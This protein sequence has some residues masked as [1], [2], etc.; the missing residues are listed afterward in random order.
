MP[1]E[2][3]PP[4][5]AA[6]F[7]NDAQ[8]LLD[9]F[10]CKRS[11]K[12][13]DFAEV[14]CDL[15]FTTLFMGREGLRELT[16]FIEE[17]YRNTLLFMDASNPYQKVGAVYLLYAL[18]MKQ[19]HLLLKSQIP[20]RVS[21]KQV[22]DI[23]NLENH[24]LDVATS[25]DNVLDLTYI[26]TKLFKMEAFSISCFPIPMGPAVPIPLLRLEPLRNSFFK[27]MLGIL[28]MLTESDVKSICELSKRHEDLKKHLPYLC[29]SA[30]KTVGGL[31][32]FEEMKE[33]IDELE[34]RYNAGLFPNK[35]VSGD[36]KIEEEFRTL[37]QRRALLKSQQYERVAEFRKSKVRAS[38]DSSESRPP[39][40]VKRGPGRPRKKKPGKRGRKKKVVEEAA[41][42]E[43]GPETERDYI[44]VETEPDDPQTEAEI[45]D[46]PEVPQPAV[47]FFPFRRPSK[48]PR[49]IR[50]HYFQNN[51]D[52][53]C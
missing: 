25:N 53:D 39:T 8:K 40:P 26:V 19:P 3:D 24:F 36:A 51:E 14:W 34:Y 49:P 11:L 10:V 50:R 15:H 48:Y 21:Y 16:E 17:C 7:R 27:E 22:W 5:V 42:T 46:N 13:S 38:S 20:I 2:R 1:R 12:F 28:R 30:P 18:Y 45:I 23:Y 6:G 37:G 4:Y 33:M 43:S 32:K 52:E 9:R 35:Q 44:Q 29:S 31:N 41:K 47:P